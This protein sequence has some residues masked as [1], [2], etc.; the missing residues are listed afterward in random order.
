MSISGRVSLML[1]GN[2]SVRSSSSRLTIHC[3]LFQLRRTCFARNYPYF[4]VD[5]LIIPVHPWSSF[6]NRTTWM[7]TFSTVLLSIVRVTRI[8]SIHAFNDPT[9][10]HV[11]NICG[12]ASNM[13]Y[14]ARIPMCHA[15]VTPVSFVATALH[16]LWDILRMARVWK[17][18]GDSANRLLYSI[19]RRWVIWLRWNIS[20]IDWNHNSLTIR[21]EKL[22]SSRP[23]LFLTFKLKLQHR[24]RKF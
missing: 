12:H 7:P 9:S 22:T 10:V 19:R 4:S 20:S 3:W 18:I 5:R 15:K 2:R 17:I 6:M 1:F 8:W 13:T 21:C 23:C 14:G 16:S 11:R 24:H